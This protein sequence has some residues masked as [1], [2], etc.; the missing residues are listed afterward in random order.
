[1]ARTLVAFH[2]HPDDEALLTSGTH[3][4]RRRRGPPRRPRA[5]PPTAALGL[6]AADSRRTADASVTRSGWQELRDERPSPRRGARRVRSAT[7][8]AASGPRRCPTRRAG[9][10]SCGPTSRRPPSG[11]PRS[12]ARSRPT[13]CSTYDANGGYGH[14]DHV[15]VHQVGARAAE[16]AGTPRVLQATVPRDTICRAIRLAGRIYRFPPEFDPTSFERAF[17]ARVGDHPPDQRPPVRRR[18]AGVDARPRLAGHRRR[19]RRPHAGGL[20]AHPA[21]GV[22]PR[23][24]PGVVRRPGAPARGARRPRRLRD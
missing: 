17:S 12:C 20:P 21:P 5:S 1:M 24:R 13:C 22:R 16:L 8:T 15:K 2:A 19:R 6:A 9:S 3:G 7:P 14:R 18:Q 23:V 10:G 11:S 4:A